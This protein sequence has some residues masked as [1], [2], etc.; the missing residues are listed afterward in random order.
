MFRGEGFVGAHL[1]A[2][3]CQ[4]LDHLEGRAH[5]SVERDRV[6]GTEVAPVVRREVGAVPTAPPEAS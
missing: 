1:S 4:Q 5:L 2:R 6:L 3:L